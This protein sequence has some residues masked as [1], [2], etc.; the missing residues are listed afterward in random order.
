MSSR[1]ALK[2]S[3]LR[4]TALVAL[5][6]VGT[7]LF[8]IEY[9]PPFRRVHLYS[10]I[11]GYHW[12]LLV[13]ALDAI[14]HG[15]FP[16]WDPS[17]YC[18]IPFAGN[19][20]ASLFYPPT[21]LLF[22]ASIFNKHVLFLTLEAWVFLHGCLALCLCFAWLRGREA[23]RGASLLGAM[24]FAYGGY[25]VSQINHVGVVTGYAWTPLAWL[26]IDQAI[27]RGSW[28]PMWKVVAASALCFLAGYPASFVAF[29]IGTIVYATAR[30]WRYGLASAVAIAASLGVAAVQ[31]LPAVEASGM[32][33]FDPKYGRGIHDVIFYLH[34]LVPDWVGFQV[35]EPHLYLYLGAPVLFGLL[36]MVKDRDSSALAVLAASAIFI[37]NP[38]GL[39]SD[40]VSRSRLLVQVFSTINFIEPATL[41]FA[42]IAANGADG[43]L[44]RGVK[45]NAQRALKDRMYVVLTAI[46]LAG[47]SIYRIAVWPNPVTGWR[48]AVEACIMFGLYV[49]GL[50]A[51]RQGH[52]W[53]AVVLCLAVLVDFKVSGTS[54]PF[55]SVPGGDVDRYY[56]RRMVLGITAKMFDAL[57]ENRQY[58]IG[59][60]GLHPT[61]MRRYGLATPQGFDPLLP[62]QYKALIEQHKAFQTNRLLDLQP[63]DLE[64]V[65]LLGVRYFLKR[66]GEKF[67]SGAP[68]DA[69]RLSSANELGI[70][71]YERR[72]AEPSWRWTGSGTATPLRWDPELRSFQVNAQGK[73]G[74]SY[75]SNSSILAGAAPSMGGQSRLRSGT[76]LSS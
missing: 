37:T 49:G 40:L 70:D 15:R 5:A 27:R 22:A 6:L 19:I 64:L 60:Q 59:L 46:L 42:L 29:A 56:P 26:G 51:L 23:S 1:Y 11:E 76:A 68:G 71:V 52:T 34:F 25:M 18:G 4:S 43:F 65:G 2:S 12:P 61:D 72:D 57:K 66:S 16:L 39:V 58:R 48:S 41:A 10:D 63:T 21:W 30:S 9:L 8:W 33:V 55:S 3:E 62:A 53:M 14:R 7:Y 50:F 38:G 45:G 28:R 74:N 69:Y 31:L 67:E 32:K 47:W 35:G 73:Q 17:I 44:R 54:H 75:S 13:T 36:W 24:G 20:Q